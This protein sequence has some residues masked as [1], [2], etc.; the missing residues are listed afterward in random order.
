MLL[1]P[2][3]IGITLIGRGVTQD[4]SDG[5]TTTVRPETESTDADDET[6]TIAVNTNQDP[7][8]EETTTVTEHNDDDETTTAA[9]DINQDDIEEEILREE[10]LYKQ[11]RPGFT[12]DSGECIDKG[13]VCDKHNDCSDGS[14]ESI[15][16]CSSMCITPTMGS[17]CIPADGYNYTSVDCRACTK[18]GYPGYRCDDGA[19]IYRRKV[20]D[21][22]SQCQDDSDE[23]Y[24]AFHLCQT[25]LGAFVNV[26][27]DL[28][29]KTGDC[30]KCDYNSEG[31]GWRC[32]NARCILAAWKCD[33]TEDCSDG[34]D[35]TDQLCKPQVV[36]E[37]K[38]E[39]T[40]KPVESIDEKET[41]PMEQ[42][43][44]S[45]ESGPCPPSWS[46]IKYSDCSQ[47]DNYVERGGLFA[48]LRCSSD[49]LSW[50]CCDPQGEWE[51]FG[52]ELTDYDLK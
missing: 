11:K 2:V 6:T 9:K 20:C 5:E 19:C 36:V 8:N 3:L 35:E 52:T 46:C 32:N 27:R 33:G 29:D 51:G 15:S 47:F 26:P 31:D 30:R 21:G 43:S 45:K 50:V 18:A 17:V 1:V 24:C 37:D 44:T 39:P 7:S 41:T 28:L 38:Q 48:D 10:C 13:G 12:C 42:S 16:C 25:E 14:D 49:Q 4:A 40:Q 22:R 23:K 34:S